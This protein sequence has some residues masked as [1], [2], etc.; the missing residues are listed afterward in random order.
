MNVI[1]QLLTIGI[2]QVPRVLASYLLSADPAALQEFSIHVAQGVASEAAIGPDGRLTA[3]S[4]SAD[5]NR[6]GAL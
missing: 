4:G 2:Y 1:G 3:K 6:V 5:W